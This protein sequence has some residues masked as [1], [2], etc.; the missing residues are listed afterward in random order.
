M[1]GHLRAAHQLLTTLF[2][3]QTIVQDEMRRAILAWYIQYDLFV[4]TVSGYGMSLDREWISA[5]EEYC[6]VQLIDSEEP[7]M[8]FECGQSGTSQSRYFRVVP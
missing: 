6:I 8:L 1:L 4:G 3:P 5:Y 7:D 2:T